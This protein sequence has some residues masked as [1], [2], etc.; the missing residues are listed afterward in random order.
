MTVSISGQFG[1]IQLAITLLHNAFLSN[2]ICYI[3][4]TIN[5]NC[6]ISER[7]S[8]LKMQKNHAKKKTI[9]GSGA[10]EPQQ[11][12]LFKVLLLKVSQSFAV[13]PCETSIPVQKYDYRIYWLC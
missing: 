9:P 8:G 12:H 5:K 7:S 10:V 2:Y 4:N 6:Q 13:S 1:L 11:K 3:P